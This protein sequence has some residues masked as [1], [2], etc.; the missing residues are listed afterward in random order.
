MYSVVLGLIKVQFTIE[1]SSQTKMLM[2]MW[3]KNFQQTLFNI[4]DS[5]SN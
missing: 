5:E 4:I 2:S 1:F 3:N